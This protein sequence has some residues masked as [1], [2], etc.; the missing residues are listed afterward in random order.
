MQRHL[1]KAT[2]GAAAVIAVVGAGGAIAA[3]K[4]SPKEE[5]QAVVND[6][7]DQ[8][9]V[10]PSALTAALKEALKNRVDAAVDD[11]RLTEAQGTAMKERIDAGELPLLGV[12]RGFDRGGRHHGHGE[13]LQ[14][15]ASY[16]GVTQT[17]LRASLADG[18]TLAQVASDRGKSV[19]GLIAALVNA[20]EQAWAQAVKDGRMTAAQRDAR[21]A[22]LKD[23][24]TELVNGTDGRGFG[25]R[26]AA[27]GPW[28]LEPRPSEPSGL[29]SRSGPP[30]VLH[31]ERAL[32]VG[33]AAAFR[34]EFL[35]SS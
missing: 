13:E 21:L 5:S 33:A 2:I 6:A 30:R 8:L 18:K 35:R 4:L 3:T 10:Q 12:G 23:R 28:I 31:A 16:L 26:P 20:R 7:A 34:P 27:R 24:M 17:A 19:D 14:V 32:G 22:G 1:K 9:G 29:A 25:P 15:A 11:G